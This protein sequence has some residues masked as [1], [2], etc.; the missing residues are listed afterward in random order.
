M[1]IP[2]YLTLCSI[3][4]AVSVGLTAC[5][6]GSSN[7]NNDSDTPDPTSTTTHYFNRVASFPVC[8]QIEANCN[9]DTET[10]AEIVAASTDGMTLV[11]TNSPKEEIGFV[12]IADPAKPT[13]EGVLAMGGEP[14]SVAVKG[15]YALVGVNTSPDYVSPS[16]VLRVVDIA[17]QTVV[18]SI[19]MGGQ[20]D[21]VAV[22]PDGSY[23]AVVIENERDEDL[24]D[25]GLPQEPAGYLMIVD[26]KGEPD[27]WAT[28]KVD[29]TGLA[30]VGPTDPEPEYVDINSDNIAVVTL[31]ENNYIVLVNLVTG[32]IVNHFTAG[33]VNLE[34]IDTKEE[35]PALISM[36]GSL[37]DVPR[38]PD[39]VS[40]LNTEQ[41]AIANEGDWNGGS[42]GF[43][44][45]NTAGEVVYDSG[46]DLEKTVVHLGHYPDS[47][48]KNK[49]NEPENAETGTF[50]D[51]KHLIIASERSNVLF[52]YD[53]TDSANPVPK[54]ILPTGTGPEGVL[55]I[56]SRNLLVA[57]SEVDSRDDV[58]RSV[59]NIYSYGKATYA[60]PTVESLDDADGKPIA[61]GAMSGLASDPNDANAVYAV[62]DS[63]YQQNR[64]F[65][66]DI[67]Q[68]PAQLT[69]AIKIKDTK[70]ILAAMAVDNG[71]ADDDVF[72]SADLAA[73]INDDGTV[74]IDPEGIAVASSGGFWIA[75]EGAGTVGDAKRP[76]TSLNMILQVD[77]AGVIERVIVLPDEVNAGQV[78]FGFEGVAEYN[79]RLYIAQQRQW[80]S[81]AN[82]FIFT[83]DLVTNGW[84]H[85]EYP[86]NAPESQNG[87]WVGLSEIT[88]LGDG[89]FLVVE[90]DNQGGP[91]AA[92]KRLYKINV[93][94]LADGAVVSK[95][96][97]RDLMD[98]LKAPGGLVPEKIEGTAVLSNGDVLII[99]DNDG[100]EDNSGET[101]LINLGKIL[102]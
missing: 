57:A 64:I 89:A 79:S 23:A 83:Y 31:Q 73:M 3:T 38:E 81:N 32:A 1:R 99:N 2:A 8:S 93:N 44:I 33:K 55:A 50:G 101:Q 100:V 65:K 43:S 16:G 47:R 59:V 78:R 13:A 46:I 52:V 74:N 94:G 85:Y 12:G 19:E 49:G 96:L 92:I 88:S 84:A 67:S 11:Y 26:L 41:F 56:P 27:A 87:G 14:T 72:S 28:R 21:S 4:L 51:K 39:G 15:G 61:W 25:G 10:A 48:S 82:P 77:A 45:L 18:R 30:D 24:G 98:D 97:V 70:G 58:I 66:L 5:G 53:A 62:E 76:V 7:N 69:E 36:T 9:D 29:M 102:D 42:R 95:T 80:G 68:K 60:Y 22:S 6:G 90:R 86:L 35:S 20:P 34:G 75:S 63:Y 40:W 37:T 17:T 91:D 54:Q 71:G